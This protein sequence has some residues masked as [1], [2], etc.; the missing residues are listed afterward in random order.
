MNKKD[1]A[2]AKFV[3]VVKNLSPE[4]FEKS[5]LKI[6]RIL[7]KLKER[8]IRKMEL[9]TCDD[10]AKSRG[11]SLVTIRRYCREGIVPYLRIGKVYRLDPP[12]VD[13]ALAQVMRENMEYRSNGIKRS[14]KRRKNFDFEAALKAL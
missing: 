1:E 3:E 13:E 8:S 14:R 12:L 5:M 10:Y 9:V 6:V 2:L 4:E 7:M 11:L